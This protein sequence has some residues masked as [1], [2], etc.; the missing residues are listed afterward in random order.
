MPKAFR[1]FLLDNKPFLAGEEKEDAVVDIHEVVG[2]DGPPS[3]SFFR[4]S[5]RYVLLLELLLLLVF[6][7]GN[8]IY[9]QR[10]TKW[11]KLDHDHIHCL[12]DI[13]D[14]NYSVI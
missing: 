13:K 10:Q 12:L 3:P 1:E 4:L 8:V 5:S 7:M 2:D 14:V 9:Q 11:C 6:T